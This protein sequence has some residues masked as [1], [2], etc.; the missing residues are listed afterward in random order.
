M[1]TRDNTLCNPLDTEELYTLSLPVTPGS[2]SSSKALLRTDDIKD[3][4]ISSVVG[5]GICGTAYHNGP[6]EHNDN[7]RTDITYYPQDTTK[8]LAPVIVEIQKKVSHEFIARLMRYSLNVFDETKILPIVLVINIDGFSSKHFCKENFVQRDNE[9]YYIL[10]SSLWAKQVHIYNADSIPSFLQVPMPKMIALVH[11]LTQQQ[12][13]IVAL[14]EYMDSTL[15]RIYRIAYH[16]FT[17]E[18]NIKVIQDTKI[19][20]FCDAITCQFK[21]VIHNNNLN[22]KTSRKRIEKYAQDGISFTENFKRRCIGE[23]ESTSVTPILITESKDLIFVKEFIKQNRGKMKWASCY[24]QGIEK[25]LFDR[26]ASYST[27]KM[28]FHRHTL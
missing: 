20:S 10:S 26:F 13:H 19:E 1:A 6:T 3:I 25:G 18:S 8:N 4:I 14:D 12:K 23:G 16:I 9:P 7:K 22:D 2:D 15:Q 21:K 27:L 17:D 24:D 11:F 5:G 28:A